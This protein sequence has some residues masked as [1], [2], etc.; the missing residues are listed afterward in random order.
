[1]K[2]IIHFVLLIWTF[3]MAWAQKLPPTTPE[4]WQEIDNLQILKSANETRSLPNEFGLFE[5][6]LNAMASVLAAAPV[7]DILNPGKK[8]ST[9][10]IPMPDGNVQDFYF[11]EASVMHPD[12]AKKYPNIK[13]YAGEGITN[14]HAK[15]FFDFSPTGFHA[16]IFDAESGTIIIEPV[17]KYDTEHYFSFY[18][19][20]LDAEEIYCGVMDSGKPGFDTNL[21]PKAGDCQLRVFTIAI[22]TTAEFTAASATPA[23]P[24]GVNNAM[25]SVNTMVTTINGIFQLELGIQIQLAANNNMLIFT[26]AATDGYTDG[27]QNAM[28]SENQ[29]IVDGIIG[30]ANYDVSHALGT[31]PPVNSGNGSAGVSL[32]IGNLCNNATKA[33]G[34]TIL[35]AVPPSFGATTLIM[36]ELGHQFGAN[37]TFNEQTQPICSN[38][39]QL[40]A[41][42]AF[43]P[44][45]GSTI[46]SYAGTCGT[47]NVQNGRD[48]YFHAISLQEIGNYVIGQGT[49]GSPTATANNQP[50]VNAG[51]DFTIPVSTPFMLTA[52]GNDADGDALTYCW[53]QMDNQLINHPPASTATNGPVFRTQLPN[54]SPTRFFPTLSAI[55]DNTIPTPWEVLPS[56]TRTMNFRVTVRDNAPG[57]GCTNEDNMMVDFDNSAGPFTV[58]DPLGTAC[59]FAGEPTT[60]NWNVANTDQAPV[61][62]SDVDIFLST[63]GGLTFPFTLLAGTPNDGTQEVML[64]DVITQQARIMVKCADNI[65]FNISP[66]DFTIDCIDMVTITDNPASGTYRARTSIET[67][68]TV[69][70][71]GFA[72][73]L[74]GMEIILNPGFTAQAGSDFL[75][76]IQ[77]CD[78]CTV[79][80]LVTNMEKV[81]KEQQ[82]SFIDLPEQEENQGLFEQ[83][84]LS[85]FPNPF[86]EQFNV[87]FE[88]KEAQEVRLYLVDV[89]G[90]LVHL[91]F[92]AKSLD[93]GV[94]RFEID[95][96]MLPDGIYDCRL[97]SKAGIQ[98]A[99]I[100]KTAR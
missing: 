18:S 63:D 62:C 21:N 13:S 98:Q 44:G 38:A 9:L 23:D 55:L 42:T 32:N 1:M 88:I 17:S 60:I 53:E 51:A 41:G 65:F 14:P 22:P 86:E 94:H 69:T 79:S 7:R 99:K 46:M 57:F 45:S 27:N 12:L 11:E 39:G 29:G 24:T 81:S 37:H 16:T 96:S 73:F 20:D 87:S 33:Q 26:N 68:G 91:L 78:P 80:P 82:V 59:L 72:E 92:E 76:R 15:I 56:V 28:A 4:L 95:G 100:V 83:V 90:R 25:A 66:A 40:N 35:G 52:T 89:T 58:N 48:R 64:P 85:V 36:H 75:A 5:L 10:S 50:T 49:C 6:E 34:A 84:A 67:M 74:A 97:V 77:A 54:P 47:S 8:S 61:N 30:S 19:K 43:E 31:N 2:Y 93:A 70:V 71:V 3:Q